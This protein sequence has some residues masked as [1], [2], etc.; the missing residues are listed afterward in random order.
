MSKKNRIGKDVLNVK[1]SSMKIPA[2]EE[3]SLTQ[4]EKKQAKKKLKE[5]LAKKAVP[6]ERPEESLGECGYDKFPKKQKEALA[7]KE[8]EESTDEDEEEGGEE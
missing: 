3:E 6:Q 8:S 4:I 1:S 5:E 2:M 7:T